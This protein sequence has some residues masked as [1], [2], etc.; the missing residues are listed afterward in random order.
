MAESWR[1]SGEYIESCNCDY[2]CPCIYTNPQ[3]PATFDHCY[4]LMAFRIDDGRFG[5]LDLSGLKFA[6]VIRSGRVMAD[7]DW[8]FAGVVDAGGSEAQQARLEQI[9]GGEVG[10]PPGMIREHLVSDFRGVQRKPIEF[11][12][13]GL[14]RAVCVPD[15]LG[16]EVAGVPSRNGSGEPVYIDNT[17]HPANSRLALAQSKSL[18][19]KGFDLVLEMM[20]EGNNG[21]YAPFGW[22]A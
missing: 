14:E 4:A 17:S 2:L 21:H 16:F 13:D 22:S 20:G 5:D 15:L 7:G 11:S 12:V 9:V 18:W 19:L 6:L 1:L 10:G 3:A 8:V